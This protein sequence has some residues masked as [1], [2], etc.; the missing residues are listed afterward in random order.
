MSD[1]DDVHVRV[2]LRAIAGVRQPS[3]RRLTRQETRVGWC[4]GRA[5]AGF[6]S[7]CMPPLDASLTSPAACAAGAFFHKETTWS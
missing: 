4:P 5:S 6:A 3:V 2:H 1:G 7:R